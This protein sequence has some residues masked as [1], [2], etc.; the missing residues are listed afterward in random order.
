MF[1]IE[2]EADNWLLYVVV[3]QLEPP[4]LAN[5]QRTSQKRMLGWMKRSRTSRCS[6]LVL[7]GWEIRILGMIWKG[8]WRIYV[9]FLCVRSTYCVGQKKK[10]LPVCIRFDAVTGFEKLCLLTYGNVRALF[11]VIYIK[12]Y[13]ALKNICSAEPSFANQVGKKYLI[14]NAIYLQLRIIC[15]KHPG[16]RPVFVETSTLRRSSSSWLIGHFTLG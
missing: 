11:V 4:N 8:L 7:W 13:I 9:I 3:A 2:I 6:S 5:A 16:P 12:S 10:C 15:F 14:M 1:A